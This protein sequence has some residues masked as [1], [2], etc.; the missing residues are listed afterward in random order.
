MYNVHD[1]DL[2]LDLNFDDSSEIRFCD[3]YVLVM[4]LIM[5]LNITIMTIIIIVLIIISDN[6]CTLANYLC[7]NVLYNLHYIYI[8]I[9]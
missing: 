6:L 5:L 3:E 8:N 2:G 9:E 1:F 4:I 7:Y